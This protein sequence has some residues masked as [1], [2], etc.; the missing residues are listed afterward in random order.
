MF[1]LS[2]SDRRSD[3]AHEVDGKLD[4]A[5]GGQEEDEYHPEKYDTEC[6]GSK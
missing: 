2:G 5:T 4:Q 6:K 1:Q 3:V